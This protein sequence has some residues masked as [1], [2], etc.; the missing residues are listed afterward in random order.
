MG[1]CRR[2]PTPRP[3]PKLDLARGFGSASIPLTVCAVSRLVQMSGTHC[4][5]ACSSTNHRRQTFTVDQVD[6]A[7]EICA[8]AADVSPSSRAS[9]SKFVAVA[10]L[11]WLEDSLIAAVE[12]VIKLSSISVRHS[13]NEVANNPHLVGFA[14][15]LCMKFLKVFRKQTL[16]IF[17]G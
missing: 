14:A 5:V 11:D 17:V 8:D 4:S 10:E 1:P 2:R 13:G 3:I 6:F 16:T 7:V 12:A 15:C 9:G